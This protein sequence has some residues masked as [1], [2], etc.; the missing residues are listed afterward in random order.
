MELP[1]YVLDQQTTAILVLD[2]QLNVRYVNHA[3]EALLQ[4]SAQRLIGAP[5]ERVLH[6]VSDCGTA[7]LEALQR[8]LGFT[9][10]EAELRTF[11]NTRLTVD[12][13]VSP[14]IDRDPPELL[15]EIRSL[16]RLQRINRED[17][18]QSLQVTTRK[19][20]QGLA[21]EIKNPLGGI[22]GAAQLL[23]RELATERL[24]DYTQVIIGEAD[25]LRNLVDRM[26]GPKA[27]MHL[28]PVNVHQVLER[29]IYLI[30]AEAHGSIR[31][32]RD[33]DPSLP[34]VEA[35]AELLI[36]AM[37]NIMRNAQQALAGSARAEI[38]VSTRI[39]RQFTIAHQRHRM[40]VRIEVRDNGPGIPPELIERIYYP[41]ISGRAEG[42]GLGLSITQSIINQMNGAIECE[43]RPGDT[44]FAV[45]L[46]LEQPNDA[47]Q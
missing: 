34:A 30:D 40:V 4:A 18:H 38:R 31:M 8:Q 39:I 17:Q 24:R 13:T 25:R 21:H 9:K 20:V 10:R 32:V 11:S 3:A 22:R 41:M 1:A 5:L 15:L 35:D 2:Q 46:P 7:L 29:V 42:S 47:Q 45:Y 14:M 16:D 23:E 12:Y 33:Y 6:D 27:R 44:Q 37:L 26:L 19:L 43:S 28:A 36:Q